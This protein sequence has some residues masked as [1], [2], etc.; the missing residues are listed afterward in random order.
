MDIV[1]ILVFCVFG[2]L[3]LFSLVLREWWLR[4]LIWAYI[5]YSLWLIL[6]T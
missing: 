1:L 5:A 6:K 4:L 2:G 3:F